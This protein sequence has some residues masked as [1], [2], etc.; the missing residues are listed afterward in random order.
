M[1][2][3][4]SPSP[5]EGVVA[6][7][8]LA[9]RL[10]AAT[11][12]VRVEPATGPQLEAAFRLRYR[13][14]SEHGWTGGDHLPHGLEC[15]AFDGA[16]VHIG[17]WHGNALVGTVRLV[18]PRPGAR[19]PVETDFDIDID[20]RGAVA[21]VGRL[22]IDPA[23]RGDPA[24]RA[25]GALFGAAWQAVRERGLAVL[26]GAASAPM[27]ER[28]R[29]R[30]LPFEVLGPARPH[31]GEDRHPVRLDPARSQPQWYAPAD[32]HREP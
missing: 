28:L 7:D 21:E 8:H 24:H 15:D 12:D 25:W 20:P 5:A 2:Q 22:V 16:A 27:V 11:L 31:W 30:G 1:S 17:A 3:D 26:A 23:Y 32:Q 10:L 6:L 4:V 14:V 13:H 18:F 9:A 19:L 29:R